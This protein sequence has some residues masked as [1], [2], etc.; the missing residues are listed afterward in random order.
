ML[1]Y[2]GAAYHGWQSQPSLPT[3]QGAVLGAARRCLGDGVRVTGASR[4][5]AGVHALG[6]VASL[7]TAGTL[8][9]A[10]VQAALNALL[11]ADVRVLEVTE[12]PE[13]FDARR[14][15]SGKRY[16]Y[17]VDNA[18]VAAPL[19]RRFA[20]HLPRPLDVAAMRR[21]LGALR[22]RHDFSAFCAAAGRDADP[23]CCVRAA[24]VVT[25]KSRI[26]ILLS[27]DRFL[28][29]M[30]RNIVGSLVQIGRGRREPAWLADVLASRDRR[31]AGATAPAHGLVLVRVRYS[32]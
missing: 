19:L 13:G 20:W 3:V 14:R 17:L 24:H 28:H 1:A 12:A 30:V 5:D 27:A 16:A 18:P 22:G 15:A 11:P 21:A 7:T 9:P 26:V 29:H 25:R 31:Q 2:D 8:A 10:A 4:T 32:G 6:Q 23:T